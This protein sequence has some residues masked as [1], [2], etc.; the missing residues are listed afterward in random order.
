MTARPARAA[1]PRLRVVAGAGRR[2]PNLGAWVLFTMLS[3][4]LFFAL[5]FSR[6]ALDAPAMEMHDITTQI[7]AEKSHFQELRLEVASL[8]APDR[9]LPRAEELG[10]VKP[11]DVRLVVAD[12]D[13]AAPENR[14]VE[15][16]S[17]LAASP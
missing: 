11:D 17:I 1:Q 7:E 12:L 15:V 10:L 3:I 13:Q 4:G 8:Q 2:R 14:W 16:K 6:I 9:I 5:I